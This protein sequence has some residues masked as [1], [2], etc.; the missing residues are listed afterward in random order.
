VADRVTDYA[1]KSLARHLESDVG[2][3][4]D[5]YVVNPT[6]DWDRRPDPADPGG[7]TLPI[8]LPYAGVL[9]ARDG[10]PPFTVGNILFE[11]NL[12]YEM[13]ILGSNYGE[14]VQLTADAKQSLRTAINPITSGVG[15]VLY[16]FAV[17]SG[18]FFANAGTMQIDI[19]Q[20]EYFGPEDERQE[21]NNRTFMSVTPVFLTAFKDSTATLLENKGRVGLTDS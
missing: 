16:N 9:L 2:T 7:G 5:V 12:E 20:S 3:F 1:S 6:F 19:G 18:A 11:R 14:M 15:V 21:K 10:D 17:A 4:S 8:S 13:T